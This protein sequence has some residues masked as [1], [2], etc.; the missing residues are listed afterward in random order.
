MTINGSHTLRGC[1][2]WNETL[3]TDYVINKVTPFVGVWIETATALQK[4]KEIQS[5]TLR[6]CVDWNSLRVAAALSRA[7]TPFVGVWIE[8]P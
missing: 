2:D 4:Y 8:T 6:G 5:H 1:V 7:V 3:T